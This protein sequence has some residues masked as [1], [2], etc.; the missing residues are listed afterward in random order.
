MSKT[1]VAKKPTV[2][3]FVALMGVIAGRTLG[4]LEEDLELLSWLN[5]KHI[6]PQTAT[7][8]CYVVAQK[9]LLKQFPKRLDE[10]HLVSCKEEMDH[11]MEKPC[12]EKMHAMLIQG[13][14][15]R[16]ASRTKMDMEA[17]YPVNK[18]RKTK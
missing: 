16:M 7:N 9:K 11:L 3:S 10:I 4:N 13:W 17:Y 1:S 2:F 18:G 15:A 8:E 14:L 6:G 12:D 5:G